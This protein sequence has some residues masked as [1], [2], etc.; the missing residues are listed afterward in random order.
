MQQPRCAVEC[1]LK[2]I[3]STGP[4]DFI[5]SFG[6]LWCIFMYYIILC[7]RFGLELLNSET[8]L[9]Y[10]LCGSHTHSKIL[11][12]RWISLKKKKTR[13]PATRRTCYAWRLECWYHII[14][15]SDIVIFPD[16]NRDNL[17]Y[18]HCACS[19]IEH[20]DA[21]DKRQEKKCMNAKNST[22]P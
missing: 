15:N 13:S 14:T 21:S 1:R 2:I 9:G 3:D 5:C 7:S 19:V 22:Y 10:A 4:N 12:C 20:G 6:L 11:L 18:D 8:S 17:F 16:V